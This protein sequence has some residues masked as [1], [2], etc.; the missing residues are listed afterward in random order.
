MYGC[1]KK[2]FFIFWAN[3][4]GL[5]WGLYYVISVIPFLTKKVGCIRTHCLGTETSNIH[6]YTVCMHNGHT[7]YITYKLEQEYTDRPT[8]RDSHLHIHVHRNAYF[9]VHTEEGR[10]T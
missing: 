7:K 10:D 2:D 1:M 5:V 4:P 6:A 3:M 9:L 8:D